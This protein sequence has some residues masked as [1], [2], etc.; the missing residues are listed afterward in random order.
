MFPPQILCTSGGRYVVRS[1]SGGGRGGRQPKTREASSGRQP[2]AIPASSGRQPTSHQGVLCF[3][4]QSIIVA[5][6]RSPEP[7]HVALLK[8]N[9]TSMLELNK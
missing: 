4:S 6:G 2:S 3:Q 8:Q 9:H 5:A 1:G 7:R